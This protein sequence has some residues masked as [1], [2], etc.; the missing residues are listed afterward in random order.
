MGFQAKNNLL[1]IVIVVGLVALT[2]LDNARSDQSGENSKT[3]AAQRS[4][5]TTSDSSL[6]NLRPKQSRLREGTQVN[7]VGRFEV[8]GDRITFY[9]KSESDPI[10]ALENLALERVA[11]ELA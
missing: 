5:N 10:R 1:A 4:N 7:L 8:T 11:R 9:P 3:Q 2:T 6:A